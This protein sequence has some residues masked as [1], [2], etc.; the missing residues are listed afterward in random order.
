MS[1]TVAGIAASVLLGFAAVTPGGAIVRCPYVGYPQ[2]CAARAAAA[3]PDIAAGWARYGARPAT[4]AA[5]ATAAPDDFDICADQSGDAA[6]A[7]CSRAIASD[8]YDGADLAVLYNN[9]GSEY[10][11]KGDSDRAMADYDQAIRLDPQYALAYGNRGRTELYSGAL[12]KALADLDLASEL[13]PKY[14]YAALWLDIVAKRSN[15]PGRLVEATTH[16]EMTR[17]PAPIIRL[18]LGQLTPAAVIAAA[19]DPNA[20]TREGQLCEAHFYIGELAL[21]QGSKER[22]KAQFDAAEALC[23]KN[24]LEYAAAA[25]ELKALDAAR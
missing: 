5:P 2:G 11:G 25:A 10:H 24:F 15:L 16:I 18:Y 21:Q 14:A 20:Y 22:A 8:R 4:F 1:A 17:W 9:R 3:Q 6:I 13:D 7:A 19:D 12:D 23:P